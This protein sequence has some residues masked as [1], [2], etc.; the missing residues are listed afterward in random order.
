[1][2]NAIRGAFLHSPQHPRIIGTSQWLAD[3]VI[4]LLNYNQN[5]K[6]M[7][8]VVEHPLTTLFDEVLPGVDHY[9][10]YY[11]D[12]EIFTQ[13]Y[14]FDVLARLDEEESEQS[15]WATVLREKI[16]I[17]WTQNYPGMHIWTPWKRVYP[18]CLTGRSGGVDN[19]SSIPNCRR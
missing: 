3:I 7:D 15:Q 19:D 2:A 13:V 16:F 18:V 9:K 5:L 12:K 11:G 8:Y 6:D 4:E 10:E 1:M 14:V 17:P